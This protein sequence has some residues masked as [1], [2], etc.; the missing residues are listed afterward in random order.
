[1]VYLTPRYH[2]KMLSIMDRVV[3][4]VAILLAFILKFYCNATPSVLIVGAGSAGIAAGS[5]L[6]QNNITNVTILEAENRIGGRIYSTK[7]EDAVVDLGAQWCHGEE[8]NTVYQLV[9]DLDLLRPGELIFDYYYSSG[10]DLDDA[11]VNELY[12][13]FLSIY[14]EDKHDNKTSLGDYVI[15]R[16]NGSITEK[17]GDDPKKLKLAGECLDLMMKK[18]LSIEGAFSW[19]D[20]SADHDYEDCEGNRLLNWKGRGFKAILD[21]LMQKLPNPEKQLPIDDKIFLNEEVTGI[22]WDNEDSEESEKVVVKCKDGS[23]YQADHVIFTP[24]LGV[25]KHNY[26][27]LFSPALPE[28]KANIIESL[29][30]GAVFK[31]FLHFPHRWWPSVNSSDFVFIWAEE[32][33]KLLLKEFPKGPVKNGTSWLINL[34]GL[35]VVNEENPKLLTAWFAGE[36]VPEI[37]KCSDDLLIDGVMFVLNKFIGHDYPNMT[38]PDSVIRKNWY[39]N[40]HF[41]GT[42]S[43]QTVRSRSY[44]ESPEIILSKPLTS[45]NGKQTLLFAGEA[46]HSIYYSTV[47]GAIETGFREA[48]RII[49]LYK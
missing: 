7:F 34:T 35:F 46:T 9:K 20:I 19:F 16:Y 15:K 6:L 38:K 28:E 47:H 45:S 8:N 3:V 31:M 48:Q 14:Y 49:D 10:E 11:F 26:K 23:V 37:E 27:S 2:L 30:I 40:P 24:S 5:K 25:L 39:S 44:A 4:T 43:Y 42:Y 41:R 18:A 13:L 36:L 33:K 17:Y 22:E 12:N 21:V 29:G 32:D 1:E